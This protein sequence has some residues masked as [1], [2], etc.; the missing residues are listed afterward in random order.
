MQ[1]LSGRQRCT[2]IGGEVM[3]LHY[4]MGMYDYDPV[5]NNFW[6]ERFNSLTEEQ[7]KMYHGGWADGLAFMLMCWDIDHISEETIEEIIIREFESDWPVLNQE[8]FVN[9]D[10]TKMDRDERIEMVREMLT[11]F[12][13][14]ETNVDYKCMREHIK[15]RTGNLMRKSLLP[16]KKEINAELKRYELTRNKM[17]IDWLADKDCKRCGDVGTIRKEGETVPCPVCGEVSS[18]EV[19]KAE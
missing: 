11:P 18:D 5:A 15:K 1:G 4:G 17:V 7:K 6:S 16:G 14:Y 10:G 3:A 13:G 2:K 8:A 9:E 12:I 19:D